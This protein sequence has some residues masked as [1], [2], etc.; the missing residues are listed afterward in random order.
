MEHNNRPQGRQKYVT[1]NSKGTARR[2]EGLNTGPVGNGSR[3]GQQPSFNQGQRSTRAGRSRSPLVGIAALLV[4]LLGGGGGLFGSGVLSGDT[5]VGTSESY[6][7][8][9]PYAGGSASSGS[10]SYAGGSASSGSSSYSSGYSGYSGSQSSGS[11]S[12]ANLL[13]NSGSSSSSSGSTG[14]SNTNSSSVDTTV[15]SGARAKRTQIYGKGMDDVT[16][17]VYMCGTDLESRSAMGTKDLVE[18][19]KASLGDKVKILVY[20]GGCTGWNNN[21]ISSKTN[22]IYEVKNGG[23]QC[24]VSNAGT[25]AMTAPDTLAG[26]IQWCAQNY[27]AN[28]NELIL[29][30]HGGG[31]VSG[32]GY[33]QKYPRSGSMTLAGINQALKKGGVTF[34]FI[35]FDACLMAT[36]ETAL[37]LD[38]YADYLIASE[39]TEPGIGWYYTNWLTKLGANPAM[40]TLEI[41]KNIVDDFV[42]TCASQCRGQS[43]TLSVIDLAELAYTAPGPMKAFAESLSE[44]IGGG[45]YS[46]VSAA[47]NGSREFARSTMIDQIDLADF[48]RRIGNEEGTELVRTLQSAVKYNRVSSDMSNAYGLSI[49]FPYRK[50]SQVDKA[51]S[52]Y[53][54][55][56]MDAS[57]SQCIRDFASLEASGQVASGGAS[58]SPFDALFG[59]YSGGYA[60]SG[61]GNYSGGYSS[62]YSG[63]SSSSYDMDA[64]GSL[65]ESFLGGG[66]SY[67]ADYGIDDFASSFLFGRSLSTADT[68]QYIADNHFD[69]SDLVWTTNSRGEE[70]IMLSE[71]QWSLVEGLDL[72]LFYDDGQGYIDLGLDNTFD[73]DEDGNL[74]AATDRTWLAVNGQPVAYYHDYTDESVTKGHVPAQLNG[75][76]VELLIVFDAE[77]PR[78]YIAGAR[79]VYLNGETDTVAKSLI[80]LETGD[81]LDFLCDYYDYEGNYLNSYHLGE[82]MTV[83]SVMEISNVDVGDGPVSVCYRFTDLYQ[84]HYWTPALIK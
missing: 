83:G 72:N 4:L 50:L 26:F 55:I 44:Q 37:M 23:L 80:E 19:T 78:G 61:S 43:A 12:Y 68:V 29:W 62:G 36:M 48:A 35:G 31:S 1:N 28:R 84:Q 65:L 49:Y 51:V 54:A 81:T 79:S 57:Y 9:Q 24:L 73:F 82:P 25:D 2:G 40:P 75:D 32:F 10:N 64:L 13:P 34:D 63:G 77:H 11:S 60:G 38:P 47:R 17:M 21:I 39:E 41:G 71:D 70:V 33:D 74:L 20:T 56:G 22:Q 76:R 59:S 69:A 18:M 14:A 3:P 8:S 5:D 45:K 30:D 42:S 67:S 15:A 6:S 46:A 7:Y 58:V 52:T 16:L 66:S 53:D 27:P